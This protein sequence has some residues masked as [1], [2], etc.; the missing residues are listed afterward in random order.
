[1][2]QTGSRTIE[3]AGVRG[4]QVNRALRRARRFG[5]TY[6]GQAQGRVRRA[7]NKV[8]YFENNK[9]FLDRKDAE[10]EA[11]V[12]AA[13]ERA[14][15]RR[16]MLRTAT[17]RLGVGADLAAGGLR[18]VATGAVGAVAMAAGAV[19]AAGGA[20][21]RG[22]LAAAAE[23]AKKL[24]ALSLKRKTKRLV[25]G[26]VQMTNAER[27]ALKAKNIKNLNSR[28]AKNALQKMRLNANR[29]N[30]FFDPDDKN[31]KTFS[32]HRE[33]GIK[34]AVRKY[35]G[36]V[37]TKTGEAVEAAKK[38]AGRGIQA[39]KNANLGGKTY[40]AAGVALAGLGAAKNAFMAGTKNAR[41]FL[42]RKAGNWKNYIKHGRRR[43]YAER[44]ENA[45]VARAVAE[46][47]VPNAGE[48][49]A[50]LQRAVNA[51]KA[52]LARGAAAAGA[53]ADKLD[54]AAGAAA[55]GNPGAA[56]AAAGAGMG[57]FGRLAG[58]GRGALGKLKG[59]FTRKANNGAGP[60]A[61]PLRDAAA[62]AHNVAG[63]ANA[64]A[65]APG[66][67]KPSRFKAIT[68]AV[69]RVAGK[70]LSAV[71]HGASAAKRG[72]TRIG[73]KLY[74]RGVAVLNAVGKV[75]KDT[76]DKYAELKQARKAAAAPKPNNG[77]AP[78]ANNGSNS[79]RAPPNG[80]AAAAAGGGRRNRG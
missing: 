49:N 64:A 13:A 21:G 27:A 62:A 32:V 53:A 34:G 59:M 51:D 4:R 12:K 3:V 45:R 40:R 56:A 14:K 63:A 5:Q 20:A 66:A 6:E 79:P 24:K 26:S 78:K 70:A 22:A 1:M 42:S 76:R 31:N 19:G 36:I 43:T 57:I 77:A 38:A 29:A 48:R 30:P 61:A 65:N 15:A 75:P 9:E 71:G 73:Q 25:F 33:G 2:G 54:D 69:T 17:R 8:K 11:A 35:A 37:A 67:V 46:G 50:A 80:A 68:N 39:I 52:I 41:G 16:E 23:A 60:A 7:Q 18:A 58:M 10:Y 55:A 28:E 72:A 47:N 44:E 74:N